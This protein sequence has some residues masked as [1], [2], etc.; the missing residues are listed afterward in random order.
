MKGLVSLYKA[1]ASPLVCNSYL[2]IFLRIVMKGKRF[3]QKGINSGWLYAVSC[4]VCCHHAWAVQ[5]HHFYKSAIGIHPWKCLVFPFQALRCVEVSSTTKTSVILSTS[6]FIVII[7]VIIIVM[8]IVI[9]IVIIAFTAAI[10][11]S[12]CQILCIS[13]SLCNVIFVKVSLKVVMLTMH[14][15]A[16]WY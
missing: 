7:I 5:L 2:C 11:L 14:I 4:F 16:Y 3:L 10:W 15:L 13:W 6:I 9:I 1:T 12:A 8:I